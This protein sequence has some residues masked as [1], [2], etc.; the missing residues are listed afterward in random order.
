M[1]WFRLNVDSHHYS[2]DCV[3]VAE[4]LLP[5]APSNIGI[6]PE[7]KEEEKKRKKCAE[8]A[9]ECITVISIFG[10]DILQN[11]CY[12]FVVVVY[13]LRRCSENDRECI[14]HL[15]F[16][17]VVPHLRSAMCLW[18]DDAKWQQFSLASKCTMFT[19]YNMH[20][21]THTS[22]PCNG[23]IVSIL[24]SLASDLKLVLISCHT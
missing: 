11:M 2:I 4:A 7:K 9:N 10:C 22:N 5:P 17:P 19:L 14:S 18:F 15:V 20:T 21:N 12:L 1:F 23:S 13:V 24:R 3:T 16:A 6:S 8:S